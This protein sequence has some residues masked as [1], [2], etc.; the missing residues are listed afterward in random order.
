[1]LI[2]IKLLLFINDCC[3]FIIVF[4][5]T[6]LPSLKRALKNWEMKAQDENNLKSQ[7]KL[8]ILFPFIFSLL[9]LIV[10]YYS[11]KH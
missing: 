1:M 11:N 4:V 3:L 8:K 9:F 7:Y 2:K 10:H 6:T 5:Q